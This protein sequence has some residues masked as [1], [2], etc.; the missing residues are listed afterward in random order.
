MNLHK[1]VREKNKENQKADTSDEDIDGL[2]SVSSVDNG[3]DSVYIQNFKS[4]ENDQK[5]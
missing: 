5:R 4:L 2:S 1:I 3:K